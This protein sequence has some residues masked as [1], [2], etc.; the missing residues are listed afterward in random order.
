MVML[1]L[2]VDWGWGEPPSRSP[3]ARRVFS[4]SLTNTPDNTVLLCQGAKRLQVQ[5]SPLRRSRVEYSTTEEPRPI[6]QDSTL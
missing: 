6:Y 3:Q 5:H 2:A 4:A 1:G